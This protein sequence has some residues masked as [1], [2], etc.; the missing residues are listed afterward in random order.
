M[1]RIDEFIE[2]LESNKTTPNERR[3]FIGSLTKKEFIYFLK[4]DFTRDTSLTDLMEKLFGS[5]LVDY[6]ET[7]KSIDTRCDLFEEY[8]HQTEQLVAKFTINELRDILNKIQPEYVTI[9]NMFIEHL[10][11]LIHQTKEPIDIKKIVEFKQ[12]LEK[13]QMTREDIR[14]FLLKM[15]KAEFSTFITL[16]NQET[17]LLFLTISTDDYKVDRMY[18]NQIEIIAEILEEYTEEEMIA[19]IPFLNDASSRIRTMFFKCL[20]EKK[21]NEIF[22]TNAPKYSRDM[23]SYILS[24]TQSAEK[25][26]IILSI[27]SDP[28]LYSLYSEQDLI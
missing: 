25:D 20:N 3:G 19:I 5:R 12:R 28:K 8:V 9:K 22:L 26:Q 15:S 27:L 6:G 16:Q 21:A 13:D 14:T 23:Y 18:E 1:Q 24:P 10:I 7:K 2:K 4:K 11:K 17:E